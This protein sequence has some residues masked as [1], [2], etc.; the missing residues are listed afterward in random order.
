MRPL[1]G[2][3][4]LLV[5]GATGCGGVSKSATASSKASSSVSTSHAA[6]NS[7]TAASEKTNG[8]YDNDDSRHLRVDDDK[9]SVRSY[10]HEATQGDK[11]VITRL[12]KR[13]FTAAAAENG[14]KACAIIDSSVAKAAPLDYGQNGPPYLRGGKTCAAVFSLLFKHDHRQLAVRAS[15]LKVTGVR[16]EGNEGFVLLAFGRMPERQ[17]AVEREGRVW[18]IEALL[19]GKMRRV[20]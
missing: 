15:R 20:P 18:K 11:S 7:T 9:L 17:I 3:L 13:Y 14:A 5:T 8:D 19:D 1:L 16:V 12:V 4:A 10:G 2:V 6:S